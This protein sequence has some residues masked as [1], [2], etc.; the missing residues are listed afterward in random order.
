MPRPTVGSGLP[1]HVDSG[2]RGQGARF[3]ALPGF[4]FPV[5][6]SEGPLKTGECSYYRPTAQGWDDA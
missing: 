1:C 5:P 2:S 4:L 3:L 6:S